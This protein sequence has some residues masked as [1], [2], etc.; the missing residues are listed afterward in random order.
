MGGT[1]GNE[2]LTSATGAVLALLLFG[3]GITIIWI[4]S[5]RDEH[6]FIGMAL[7]PPLL[8]KLGSTG[9]RFAR[10]Y[11]R[12]PA[13]RAKGPPLLPMR[14]L[15]PVLVVLT[16]VVFVTGVVLLLVGHRSNTLFTLHKISFIVWSGFFVVHFLVYVPRVLRSLRDDWTPAARRRVAGAQT[17][18]ALML[19][20][21]G[22]GVALALALLPLISGW[23]GH[24]HHH[25]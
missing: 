24:H 7:I 13:Y 5:L 22:G 2:V 21:I 15:A 18:L 20:S 1:S 9:Y 17:R 11:L 6:M 19:A 25:G 12:T 14:L 4:G 10:Y 23:H 16:L 3:E 8:L